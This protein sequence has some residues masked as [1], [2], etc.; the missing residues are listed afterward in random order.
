MDCIIFSMINFTSYRPGVPNS[1]NKLLCSLGLA[2]QFLSS[3][4]QHLVS[5][6]S[7][8]LPACYLFLPS[9]FFFFQVPTPASSFLF[10]TDLPALI[11]AF[12]L[13]YIPISCLCALS[14]DKPFFEPLSINWANSFF[15]GQRVLLLLIDSSSHPETFGHTL[16]DI[17]IWFN[18]SESF[19]H[20]I[21]LLQVKHPQSFPSDRGFGI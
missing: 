6:F 3:V 7:I 18:I 9:S 2:D 14:S 10:W 1:I 12:F 17:L 16:Y 11:S 13:D 20:A 21:R 5:V 4:K 8:T 15:F 19:S